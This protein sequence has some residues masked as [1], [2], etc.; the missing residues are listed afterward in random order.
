MLYGHAAI[1][2]ADFDFISRQAFANIGIYMAMLA[3]FRINDVDKSVLI[4][5][6]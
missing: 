2:S 4:I 3:N 6:S 1:S 5:F